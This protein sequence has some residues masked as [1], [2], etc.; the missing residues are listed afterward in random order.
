MQNSTPFLPELCLCYTTQAKELPESF[1]GL[2]EPPH[3]NI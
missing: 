3:W 2:L 1:W